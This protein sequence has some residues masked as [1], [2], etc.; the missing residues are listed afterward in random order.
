MDSTEQYVYADGQGVAQVYPSAYEKARFSGKG[1]QAICHYEP[2]EHP[3]W[4]YPQAEKRGLRP[5]GTLFIEQKSPQ[6][7]AKLTWRVEG[8]RAHCWTEGHVHYGGDRHTEVL[9]D[10][11]ELENV[12]LNYR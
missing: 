8:L 2:S 6:H 5:R 4:N 9:K 7:L 10:W 12:H 11:A 3:Y 1:R